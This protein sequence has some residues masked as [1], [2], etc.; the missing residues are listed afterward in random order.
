MRDSSDV[1]ACFHCPTHFFPL[2]YVQTNKHTSDERNTQNHVPV[3]PHPGLIGVE[4]RRNAYSG[5]MR[6]PVQSDTASSVLPGFG[7]GPARAITTPTHTVVPSLQVPGKRIGKGV[8]EERGNQGWS[9][10]SHTANPASAIPTWTVDPQEKIGS[11]FHI[12]DRSSRAHNVGDYMNMSNAV[13]P[14]QL[15]TNSAH[16]WSSAR[17][18]RSLWD[19]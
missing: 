10:Q 8:S 17:F 13:A 14:R 16:R 7:S 4:G 5:V 12:T 15:M 2:L 9:R 6:Y 1:G 11:E 18:L 19:G 3:T